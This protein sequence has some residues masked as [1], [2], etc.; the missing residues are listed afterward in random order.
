[1]ALRNLFIS[2]DKELPLS[3]KSVHDVVKNVKTYFD[4][5]IKSLEINF[6]NS[7]SI[8]S[9]NSEFLGHKYFTDVISFDYSDESNSFDGEIFICYEVAEKNSKRFRV[10][11]DDELKRLIIHGLLHFSEF[12][13]KMPTLRKKMKKVEDELMKQSVK[14]K[15]LQK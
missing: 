13:D 7:D 1:M 15:L 4:K 2:V 11:F 6:V 12:D 9:I 3:K 14:I 5:K 8:Y 10:S